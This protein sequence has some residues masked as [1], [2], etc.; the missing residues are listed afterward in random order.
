VNPGPAQVC[1]REGP[2]MK[3]GGAFLSI[4]FDVSQLINES[5]R[6]KNGQQEV[7]EIRTKILYISSLE[8]ESLRF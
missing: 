5:Y 6:W 8:T 1:W 3:A 2:L 7:N 4:I